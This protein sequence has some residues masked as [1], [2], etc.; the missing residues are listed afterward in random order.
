MLI[1][2]LR[3]GIPSKSNPLAPRSLFEGASGSVPRLISLSFLELALRLIMREGSA[4]SR[5]RRQTGIRRRFADMI[6]SL[7]RYEL[8]KTDPECG[9]GPCL[10]R[11]IELWQSEGRFWRGK[12]SAG[13]PR[14]C[15]RPCPSTET[16]LSPKL[17]VHSGCPDCHK[18][19]F[20]SSHPP[21]KRPSPPLTATAPFSSAPHR[22]ATGEKASR[23]ARRSRPAAG[24]RSRPSRQAAA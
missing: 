8:R 16:P 19:H 18:S 14:P 1:S 10:L 3:P 21:W 4:P 20:L 12:R 5:S 13:L 24:A 11:N 9:D 6:A 22:P 17:S 7:I 23:C 15:S 2:Q